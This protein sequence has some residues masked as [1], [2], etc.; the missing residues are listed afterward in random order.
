MTASLNNT[1][2]PPIATG[3]DP[4]VNPEFINAMRAP[5]SLDIY[6]PGVRWQDV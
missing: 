3:V 6:N 5:T 4:Y 2:N 1:V